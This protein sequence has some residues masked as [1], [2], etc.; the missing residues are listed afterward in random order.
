VPLLAKLE[1]EGGD[2]AEIERVHG[3]LN[4]HPET[5]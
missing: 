2:I 5:D 4:R 3:I 1:A